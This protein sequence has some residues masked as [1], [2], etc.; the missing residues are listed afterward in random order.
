MSSGYARAVVFDDGL[1]GSRNQSRGDADAAPLA[2]GRLERIAQEIS[3]ICS[4]R[5]LIRVHRGDLGREISL[6][7]DALA[8]RIALQ[9]RPGHL[10]CLVDV[11]RVPGGA[12]RSAGPLDEELDAL[13]LLQDGGRAG[14]HAGSF[15]CDSSRSSALVR[16]PVSGCCSSCASSASSSAASFFQPCP[17]ALLTDRCRATMLHSLRTANLPRSRRAP[18]HPP[19]AP[20]PGSLPARCGSVDEKFDGRAR[21]DAGPE[22]DEPL[23]PSP[24]STP[25]SRQARQWGPPPATRQNGARRAAGRATGAVPPGRR[26]AWTRA[27]ELLP[28]RRRSHRGRRAR[29]GPPA[30]RFPTGPNCRRMPRPAPNRGARSAPPFDIPPPC[31]P[32]KEEPGLRRRVECNRGFGPHTGRGSHRRPGARACGRLQARFRRCRMSA[33]TAIAFD[34]PPEAWAPLCWAQGG[35][36]SNGGALRAPDSAPAWH[37][38]TVRSSRKRIAGGLDALSYRDE[39]AGVVGGAQQP[40]SRHLFALAVTSS[41]CAPGCPS[42]TVLARRWRRAPL[43]RLPGARRRAGERHGAARQPPARHPRARDRRLLGRTE[44]ASRWERAWGRA[45]GGWT[46]ARRDRGSSLS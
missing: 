30:I 26:D 45:A 38:A 20:S 9:Q 5:Q 34:P 6:Q 17:F 1:Y 28:R 7:R 16:M 29:P 41:C 11:A 36:M 24:G 31:G 32:G 43:P 19:A 35:G 25:S 13:G 15:A 23:V 37:P 42:R 18:V 33:R 14:A 22:A 39:I 46:G 21:A 10:D 3:E 4:K 8:G 2:G 27:A 44:A 40:V 12:A